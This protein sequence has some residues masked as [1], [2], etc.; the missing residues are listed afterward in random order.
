MIKPIVP[1]TS[2]VKVLPKP[3]KIDKKIE[4]P[5]YESPISAFF[6]YIIYVTLLIHGGKLF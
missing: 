4:D 6:L 5:A 3:S 1:R 2:I